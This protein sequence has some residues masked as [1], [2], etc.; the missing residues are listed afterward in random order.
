MTGAREY[1]ELFKETGLYGK[2]YCVVGS[3][4]RGKTFNVHVL[5]EG[6]TNL[7]RDAVEVYGIKSGDPGWTEIYGWLHK[8]PWVADFEA[9]VQEKREEKDQEHRNAT[10][11][12]VQ[13]VEDEEK[14]KLALLANY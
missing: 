3:H 2:L 10:K 13:R 12:H 11:I 9:I 6:K 1:A 5:P 8:G 7:N 4:A 14:R